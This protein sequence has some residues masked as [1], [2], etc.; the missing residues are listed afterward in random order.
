MN[1]IDAAI[2]ATSPKKAVVEMIAFNRAIPGS[3]RPLQM[4]VPADLTTE[5]ALAIVGLV[6]QLPAELR[7]RK[8]PHI[9]H[10]RGLV[11]K[12]LS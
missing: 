4:A 1:D 3:S 10:A 5:E 6:I 2:K 12:P 11:P 8:G 7:A 9:L